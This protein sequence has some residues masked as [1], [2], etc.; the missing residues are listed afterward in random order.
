VKLTTEVRNF[1]LRIKQIVPQ[2][3]QEQFARNIRLHFEAVE[4][5]DLAGCTIAGALLGS[6]CEILPLDVL[7]GVDDW[8][9]I[10]AALG[11]WIGYARSSK[12]RQIR[13]EI[14]TIIEEEVR[15]ALV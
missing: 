10:G 9:E 5:D 3:K 11:A 12:E 7:T 4:M 1:L 15:R 13:R 6:L 2:E 14:Q 8:V